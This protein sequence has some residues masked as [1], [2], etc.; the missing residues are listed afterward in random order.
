MY[1]LQIVI[2]STRPGRQGPTVAAWMQE[3]ALAHAKFDVELVDLAAFNLP[4]FDEPE[5]PR[6]AKYVHEHTKRWSAS[7]SRAD[8]FVFVQPEYNFTAPPSLLNAMQY[9]FRE[10]N[11]KP[12]GF[13]SYGGVSGGLRSVQAIKPIVTTLKLV[14]LLEQVSIHGLPKLIDKE[15]GVFTPGEKAVK[16]AAAMLDELFRWTAALKTLRA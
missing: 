13:C 8:A 12:V 5:H 1:T 3:Q 4:I 10:W 15:T 11:Y 2:A 6:H 16:D 14:P 9:L 7:V